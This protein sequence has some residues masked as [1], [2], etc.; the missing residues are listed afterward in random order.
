M[1]FLARTLLALAAALV[2]ALVAVGTAAATPS[3]RVDQVG[4]VARV[5]LEGSYVGAR[6]TVHRENTSG[7]SGVVVGERD[8]LCTGDCYV[9]DADALEGGTYRYR[10]DVTG[11]DGLL[12][13]YG[14]FEVVIGGRAAVGL[15]LRPSPNPVR[16]R[17]TLR[18]TAALARGD[19]ATD[20]SR[21]IGLPGE[22]RLMDPAGRTVRTL[23]RGTLD[24]LTFDLPFEARDARGARLAPGTYILVLNTAGARA[25]QRVTIVR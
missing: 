11:T 12:R 19:R 20:A 9:L 21:A 25:T 17:A 10:F 15:S 7:A 3:V 23:W 1:S 8:A 16:D 24:R 6:Y 13:S 2:I 22:V 4:G 18:V 5:T 14:P